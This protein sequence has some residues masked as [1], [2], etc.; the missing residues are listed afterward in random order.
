M[1]YETHHEGNPDES[2]GNFYCTADVGTAMAMEAFGAQSKSLPG[3]LITPYTMQKCDFSPENKQK[4]R[5]DCIIVV[6]T[7]DEIDRTLK[8][9]NRNGNTNIPTRI[10]GRPRKIWLIELGYSSD[11]RYMNKVIEKIEQHQNCEDCLPQRGMM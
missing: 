2:L 5:P 9:R 3:W 4:L 6:I 8:K 11:T 7:N 10:N 1:M